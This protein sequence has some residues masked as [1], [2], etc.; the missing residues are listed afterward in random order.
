[1]A[2]G[3]AGIAA[4]LDL[5][6]TKDSKGRTLIATETAIADEIAAAA[7]LTKPKAGGN[8]VVIVRG[9]DK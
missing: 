5:R 7:E 6:G 3:C 2:L 8:P 1:M 4:I 9:L